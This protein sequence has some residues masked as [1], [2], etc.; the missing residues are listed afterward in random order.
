MPRSRRQPF[1]PHLK[2][3][4]GLFLEAHDGTKAM[5]A[6]SSTA[7]TQETAPPATTSTSERWFAGAFSA[8]GCTHTMTA[9]SSCGGER[10]LTSSPSRNV[11]RVLSASVATH[12]T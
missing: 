5:R 1:V 2:N 10:S 8:E 3:E 4:R 6:S 11:N 7:L 9:A 12:R